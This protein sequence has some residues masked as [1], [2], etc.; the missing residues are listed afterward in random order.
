MQKSIIDKTIE[1]HIYDSA[2]SLA[3]ALAKSKDKNS[4]SIFTEKDLSETFSIISDLYK[5]MINES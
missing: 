1:D 4:K 2:E 5:K 3:L